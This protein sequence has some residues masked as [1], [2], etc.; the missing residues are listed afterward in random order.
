MSNEIT[1]EAL[2]QQNAGG[3]IQNFI[4]DDRLAHT[5]ENIRNGDAITEELLTD[6]KNRQDDINTVLNARVTEIETLKNISS[7]IVDPIYSSDPVPRSIRQYIVALIQKD[8]TLTRVG[9]GSG[10]LI[11]VDANNASKPVFNV[12][13]NNSLVTVLTG[14]NPYTDTAHATSKYTLLDFDLGDRIRDIKYLKGIIK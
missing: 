5:I 9:E 3:T 1:L 10:D 6:L 11:T 13:L 12:Y 2:L 8:G 4:P 14:S 7:S